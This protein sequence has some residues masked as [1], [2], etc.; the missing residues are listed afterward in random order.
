VTNIVWATQQQDSSSRFFFF[1]H[2]GASA[3]RLAHNFLA[4]AAPLHFL[5]NSI[6]PLF[7]GEMS[8]L[9]TFQ[10]AQ[11]LRFMAPFSVKLAVLINLKFQFVVVLPCIIAD[12][13]GREFVVVKKHKVEMLPLAFLNVGVTRVSSSRQHSR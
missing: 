8:T 6:L 5:D 9:A 3:A 10:A 13:L 7:I 12:V 1:F 2:I 11:C 4:R